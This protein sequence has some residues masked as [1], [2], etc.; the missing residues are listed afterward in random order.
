MK[1]IFL[2]LFF[3]INL[4]AGIVE[5]PLVSVDN[6]KELAT[7]KIANINVGMSGFITHQISQSHESILKAIKVVSY[8]KETKIA[9]LKMSRY[10]AL[11]INSALPK[12]LWKVKVGDIAILAFGYSRGLLIAPNEDIYYKI[13]KGVKIQWIHPDLFATL[14]SFNGH[15]TP[16]KEDF[17]S[18]SDTTA[19]GLIFFFIN[20]KLFML[21]SKS[22]RIL[23]ITN[24]PFTQ[25]TTHLPFYT[26]V[27][28]IHANWWGAGSS[29]VKDYEQFYY[30]ILVKY[31][32]TN[33]DLYKIIKNSGKKYKFLLDKFK[34]E[35]KK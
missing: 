24:A 25:K 30:K 26:R 19:I 23:G 11:S 34:I 10:K 20:Q 22:F 8:D 9:T 5:V 13:T 35:E 7:I 3:V 31:N 33:K 28:K 27:K 2:T 1:Y 18:M 32:K 6:N 14:L 17:D 16:L 12:G 29:R 15:P 4:F 21:D